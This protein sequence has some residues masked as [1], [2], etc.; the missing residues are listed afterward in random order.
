MTCHLLCPQGVDPQTRVAYEKELCGGTFPRGVAVLGDS[1]SAH[2]HLPENWFDATKI[3]VVSATLRSS[4]STP[5]TLR[6]TCGNPSRMSQTENINKHYHTKHSETHTHTNTQA[7]T[8]ARMHTHT[9][10][11]THTY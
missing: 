10:T 6:L 4:L 8:H 1:V 11:H 7:S 9:H 3:S 5:A 2:F